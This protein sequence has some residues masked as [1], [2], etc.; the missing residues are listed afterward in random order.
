M[1]KAS[2]GISI[3]NFSAAVLVAAALVVPVQVA[4]QEQDGGLNVGVG[5]S[6]GSVRADVG[7]T[8]GSSSG[9]ADA[10]VGASVGGSDGINADVNANVGGSRGLVDAD[11]NARV[12]GGNGLGAN[13]DARVGGGSLLDANVG[14]GLGATGVDPSNPVGGLTGS[15]ASDRRILRNFSRLSQAERVRMI[16]RCGDIGDGGYDAGLVGL[17]RLLQTASR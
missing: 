15:T 17:C 13:V 14:L 11:V 16:K 6:L 8:V 3:S 1:L 4:A 9:L 10:N 7:A 2:N 12:G 5:V